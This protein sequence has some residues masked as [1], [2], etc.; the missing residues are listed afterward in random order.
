MQ[1]PVAFLDGRWIPE[2]AAAVPVGDAGFVL[3]ATVTEQ[4][5]TFAG[6]LFRLDEHLARLLYSLKI[7]GVDPGMTRDQFATLAREIVAR[8]HCL[9]APNDDLGLSIFVTPGGY[10]AY[11]PPGP[12]RPTVCLHTYPL[13][14]HLWVDKYRQGQALATTDIE[15]VSPRCWPADLKCRSRMHFYLADRQ[16]RVQDPQA[17]AL[18]FDAQGFATEASTANVLVC[19]AAEG[20]LSPP[21]QKIL[22][23]ISLAVV[24]DLARGLGIPTA[25]RDLTAEEVGSAD[26]VWLTSTPMCLLPVVRF[27]GR[28]IGAGH[29][30][31]LFHRIL[32]AWSEMVGI[33]IAAQAE[34]HQART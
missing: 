14:F 12:T 29:P 1:E 16:A 27:N 9:L 13:P 11:S 26:E 10:P 4:L 33:D 34:A 19:R 5:R 15:Q 18:L 8:N 21:A 31:P 3:G 32:A 30:G 17:R 7:I 6:E 2:S 28:P 20:L 25:E 22:H 23:G 24:L